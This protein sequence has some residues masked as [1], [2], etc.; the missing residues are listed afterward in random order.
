[1][2]WLG[3]LGNAMRERADKTLEERKREEQQQQMQQALTQLL[4]GAPKFEPQASF[5]P[6]QTKLQGGET[7]E[8]MK[9]PGQA[10]A[11]ARVG[12]VKPTFPNA[13]MD[14]AKAQAYAQLGA[15]NPNIA[16]G[17]VSS[18]LNKNAGETLGVPA[19][20]WN[21]LTPEQQ[22]AAIEKKLGIGAGGGGFEGTG[23]DAQAYNVLLSEDP[24]TPRYAAMYARMAQPKVQI[25]KD[26]N[27]TWTYPDMSWARKPTARTGSTKY[28]ALIDNANRSGEEQP[29]GNAAPLPGPVSEVPTTEEVDVAAAADAELRKL[30]VFPLEETEET[31][32]ENG[33]TVKTKRK[34]KKLPAEIAGKVAAAQNYIANRP[35]VEELIFDPQNKG[36][37]DRETIAGA[38][39]IKEGLPMAST[40]APEK[41]KQLYTEIF[42]AVDAAIRISTGAQANET[43]MKSYMSAFMPTVGDSDETIMLKL[44]KLEQFLTQTLV[45]AG[46]DIPKSDKPTF[47]TEDMGGGP[48]KRLKWNPE[49]GELE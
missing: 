31:R 29:Y 41:S 36:L 14:P 5:G 32:T 3:A 17:L 25:D 10:D 18:T 22:N 9:Q 44:D 38:Q 30:G 42:T 13:M 34:G 48:K 2:S 37:P 12:A 20:I 45:N 43:E 46:A 47:G 26:G 8:W 11:T 35:R 40:L 19:A 16:A 15:Q 33:V 7:I 4:V 21:K 6:A 28:D 49:T 1:M 24:S 23:M 27:E 39:A